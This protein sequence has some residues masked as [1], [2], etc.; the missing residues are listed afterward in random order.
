MAHKHIYIEGRFTMPVSL[1]KSLHAKREGDRIIITCSKDAH[2]RLSILERE[3]QKDFS[4]SI[5]ARGLTWEHWNCPAPTNELC[6]CD[7]YASRMIPVPAVVEFTCTQR[8]DPFRYDS[9][10]LPFWL[11]F[12][13]KGLPNFWCHTLEIE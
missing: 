3:P 5:N 7:A 11:Q 12:S 2:L 9:N 4:G 6:T 1:G 10:V 8:R 13:F